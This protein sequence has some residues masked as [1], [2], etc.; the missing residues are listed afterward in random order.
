MSRMSYH[1]RER[2]KEEHLRRM[3]EPEP[4]RTL[5]LQKERLEHERQQALERAMYDQKAEQLRHEIEAM[6]ETPEA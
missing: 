4:Y 2:N 5:R 6:G 3:G 1:E